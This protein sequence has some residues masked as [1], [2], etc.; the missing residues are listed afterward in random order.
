M[1]L[2]KEYDEDILDDVEVPVEGDNPPND[3][4]HAFHSALKNTILG[5]L[6]HQK[7]HWDKKESGH[8][9][10]SIVGGMPEM[11]VGPGQWVGSYRTREKFVGS[12]GGLLDKL[13]EKWDYDLKNDSQFILF[14]A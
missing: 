9:V 13:P 4:K 5:M 6:T 7:I 3:I 10:V 1:V 14:T 8:Y 12:D 11:P 2:T